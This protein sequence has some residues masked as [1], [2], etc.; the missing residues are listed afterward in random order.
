VSHAKR[1][2]EKKREVEECRREEKKKREEKARLCMSVSLSH[3]ARSHM[4]VI[5][6]YN[7]SKQQLRRSDA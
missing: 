7:K 4:H 5:R 6:E 1:G 3:L 2:R